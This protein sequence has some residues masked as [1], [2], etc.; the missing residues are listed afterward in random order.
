MRRVS[1]NGVTR[2]CDLAGCNLT[3]CGWRPLHDLRG[4]EKGEG[5]QDSLIGTCVAERVIIPCSLLVR[6]TCDTMGSHLVG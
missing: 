6:G 4:G 1:L 5:P 3:P 2:C